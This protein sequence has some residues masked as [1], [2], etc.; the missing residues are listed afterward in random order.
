MKSALSKAAAGVAIALFAAC[1]SLGLPEAQT[2]KQRA[3]VAYG[4]VTAVRDTTTQLLVAKKI[5]ADSARNVQRQADIA[6]DSVD[7]AV[8]IYP[9]SHVEGETRLDSAVKLLHALQIYLQSRS[10][11]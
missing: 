8:A 11:Q 9:S 5:S 10:T 7:A 4:T 3:V 2:F 6:R 1:N